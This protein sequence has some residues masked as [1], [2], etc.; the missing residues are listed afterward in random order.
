MATGPACLRNRAQHVPD[1]ADNRRQWYRHH[2]LFSDLLQH[3]LWQ[4]RPE[5]IAELNRRK[6]L[7]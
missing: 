7:A 1:L 5:V 2:Q 4:S 3:R 6:S